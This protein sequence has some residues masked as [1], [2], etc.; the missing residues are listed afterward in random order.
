M[1]DTTAPADGAPAGDAAATKD[2]HI[3]IK[4]KAQDGTEI[5]F[6]IKRSTQLKKLMDAYC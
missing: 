4:V 6:K 3:N 1:A 5:Y 2:Q